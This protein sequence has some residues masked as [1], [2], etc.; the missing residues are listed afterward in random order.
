MIDR[1]K[2]PTYPHDYIICLDSE[3][4]FV[5]KVILLNDNE[6]I[7]TFT[8]IIN[9]TGF[10]PHLIRLKQGTISL[11]IE[12]FLHPFE[13]TADNINRVNTLIKKCMKKYHHA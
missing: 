5:A 8:A 7:E 1:S 9:E 11:I 6:A 13:K 10:Q 2:H 3:V 4:G 12:D